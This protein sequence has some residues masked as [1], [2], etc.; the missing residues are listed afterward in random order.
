MKAT[1]SKIDT[2][3]MKVKNGNGTVTIYKRTRANGTPGFE[4]ADYTSGSRKLRS[5]PGIEQARA[6][7]E[8]IARMLATG[9]AHAAG[10][11]GRELA[12]YGRAIELLRPTGISLEIAAATV[13]KAVELLGDDRILEACRFFAQHDPARLTTRTVSEVVTELLTQRE[14]DGCSERHV[15]DLRSRLTRFAADFQVPMS[16]VTG[17][18]LQ[19]WLDRLE[20]APKTKQN[21]KM[22]ISNLFGFAIRRNYYPK[23]ENP[24][25]DLQTPKITNGK[26]VAIYT[27]AELAGLLAAAPADFSSVVAI[28]AMAGLR[29]AEIQHLDWRDVKLA[30]G[31]IEVTAD[32]AK[33][34][35]RRI[36]PICPAL[37]AWLSPRARKTGKVWTGTEHQFKKRQHATSKNAGIAWK[38]NALRHSFCSYRLAEVQSAAQV[39]LEAGNSPTMI[40]RHY[41]ELVSNEKAKAWFNILPQRP[42]NIV[43]LAQVA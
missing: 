39:A 8:R 5:F 30:E 12:G 21:A 15:A 4:L 40:F 37:A 26:A 25:S 42:A 17:Q 43:Q 18:D 36:V 13:A 19:A 20:C 29:I 28:G 2:F 34:A 38:H 27:P 24:A 32:N 7:A 9:D 23:G 31:H 33:T 10:V 41:R 22:S 3:P 11:T 16:S 6:E 1:Q 35:T 14:L